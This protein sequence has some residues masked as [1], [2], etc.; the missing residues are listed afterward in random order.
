MTITALNTITTSS[1]DVLGRPIATTDAGNPAWDRTY[2]ALGR[3]RMVESPEDILTYTYDAAGNRTA[4]A[5]TTFP[6]LGYPS[7]LSIPATAYTY[8]AA[9]RMETVIHAGALL[10]TYIPDSAGRRSILARTNG[11]TTTT[12]YDDAERV[13]RLLTVNSQQTLAD[14][15]YTYD[16]G[17]QR[18]QVSETVNGTTRTLV[19]VY[20]A[21]GRLGGEAISGGSTTIYTYDKVGNRLAVTVNSVPVL[22][23]SYNAANQVVGWTYDRAGNLLDDGTTTYAYD[24]AGRLRSSAAT[25]STTYAY[26]D[27][28]LI[29]STITAGQTVFTQDTAGGLSRILA[30]EVVGISPTTSSTEYEVYGADGERLASVGNTGIYRYPIGDALGTVRVTLNAS[31]SN[32]GASQFTAWG[33]A[34]GGTT[35]TPFGF[36]GELTDATSG[37]VYLRARWYNPAEGTLMGRD[38]FEGRSEQPESLHQYQYG[39]NAPTMHTDPSGRDPWWTDPSDPAHN[40]ANAMP[41]PGPAPS[42]RHGRCTA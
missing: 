16:R 19:Y 36:T 31:G 42:S 20:D 13:S 39:W 21:L 28:V 2:D 17:G 10:A 4:V 38:P 7:S 37:L 15:G 40:C 14:F 27:E 32:I 24:A 35:T 9:G 1:Y 23:R 5:G 34:T 33:E 22:Q 26:R 29:Q 25:A 30:R 41:Y 3:L 6:A 12:T 18:V 11:V 8:D